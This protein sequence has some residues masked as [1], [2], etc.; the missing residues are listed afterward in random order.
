MPKRRVAP[1]PPL[2]GGVVE[3]LDSAKTVVVRRGV[4]S[5]RAIIDPMPDAADTRSLPPKFTQPQL[6]L[7]VKA[8]PFGPN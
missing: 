4:L 3:S 7:L 8:P 2:L 6:S 1:A 5:F